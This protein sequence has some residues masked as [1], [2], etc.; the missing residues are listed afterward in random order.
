MSIDAERIHKPIRKL[1]QILKKLP[2]RPSSKKIHDLRTNARRFEATVEALGFGRSKNEKKLLRR[3]ARL[4]K[5]AGKVRDMDVLIGYALTTNVDGEQDCLMHVL[6]TLAANRRRNV[7]RLR[8]LDAGIGP[9]LRRRLKRSKS[10]LTKSLQD[11]QKQSSDSSP[12][13]PAEALARAI[14]LA[15]E[16]KKPPRLNKPNLHPYRLKVKDLRYILQLAPDA[17]QREFVNKLGEVK[18]AIGE[19]H[20]WEELCVIADDVRHHGAKCKL[21]PKLRSIADT[22]YSN[23]IALANNLRRAFL[24]SKALTRARSRTRNRPPIRPTVLAATAA[25]TN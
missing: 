14:R 2:K 20:D 21:L 1:R 13:P 8:A 11:T 25:L 12:D 6:E 7:R 5:C 15:G 9:R 10:K 17:D 23:A 19:W 3:L 22:K 4:R 16:L 18:D 24:E